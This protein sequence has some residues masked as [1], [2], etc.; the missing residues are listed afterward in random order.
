MRFA[1]QLILLLEFDP[2]N[3]Q[4]TFRNFV[5]GFLRTLLRYTNLW[6]SCTQNMSVDVI[7]ST[8]F[9]SFMTEKRH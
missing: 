8:L 4:L 2:A 7:L 9:A 1:F 5:G 3:Q 6:Q